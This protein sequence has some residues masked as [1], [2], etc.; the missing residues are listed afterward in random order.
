MA[1]SPEISEILEG[2]TRAQLD[3]EWKALAPGLE[4]EGLDDHLDVSFYEV[5]E[6]SGIEYG[7]ETVRSNPALWRF[8]GAALRSQERARQ[9]A[10]YP[11]FE[12]NNG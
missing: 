11:K 5:V 12:E 3:E 4:S 7:G 9:A 6:E 10:R 8:V 1:A 2:A